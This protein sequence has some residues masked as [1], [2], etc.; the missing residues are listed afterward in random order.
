MLI[1]WRRA[2]AGN[3]L[4]VGLVQTTPGPRNKWTFH[5]KKTAET[6]IEPERVDV[7]IVVKHE[8]LAKKGLNMRK[9]YG[10]SSFP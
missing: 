7:Q 4:T 10:S 8:V 6:V 3:R 1:G 9:M 2:L 5:N